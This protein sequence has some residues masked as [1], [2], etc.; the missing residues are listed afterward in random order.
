MVKLTDLPPELLAAVLKEL[1]WDD[2]MRIKRV[3][4]PQY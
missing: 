2:L 1:D 4:M 3:S